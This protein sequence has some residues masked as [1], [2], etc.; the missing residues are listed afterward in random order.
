MIPVIL[1][2]SDIVEEFQLTPLQSTGLMEYTIKELTGTFARQWSKAANSLKSS[3]KI[4][5][6]SIVIGDKGPFIGVV[7][8]TNILPNMIENGAAPFDMKAGFSRGTKVKFKP[9]GGWYLTIPQRFAVPTALGESEVFS[10][11]L[12]AAI[13]SIMKNRGS[14]Q[15]NLGGK[16]KGGNPLSLDEI[17][18]EF[19]APKSRPQIITKSRTYEEYQHKHSIY[20]GLTR[21]QKTYES[22]TSGQYI[23]FRRASDKS[24]SNAWIHSGI[25]AK[26]LAEKAL[27]AMNIEFE[28]DKAA[29]TYL[30]NIGF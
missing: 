7:M 16:V 18:T 27:G 28:I 30:A 24:D 3:R 4:Y 11:V 14:S 12:P 29:D 25:A 17:P 9:Q 19:Q 2:V 20:E 10:G 21:A 13:Y 1:D 22:S 6:N 8:L 23:T 5:Q 15:S 26:N